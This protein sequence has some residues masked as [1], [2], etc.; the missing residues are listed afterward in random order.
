MD[1]YVVIFTAM[2]TIYRP[3]PTDKIRFLVADSIPAR[4]DPSA[5]KAM[6]PFWKGL[7]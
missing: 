1:R 6:E 2:P 7:K 3:K 4:N 5:W